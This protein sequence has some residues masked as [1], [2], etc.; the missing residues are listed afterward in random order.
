MIQS[1]P[2][3]HYYQERDKAKDISLNPTH[4][5][6]EETLNFVTASSLPRCWQNLTTHVAVK[7]LL[8]AFPVSLCHTEFFVN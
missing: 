8:Y 6:L 7:L 3:L 1:N 4:H 5:Q 2:K